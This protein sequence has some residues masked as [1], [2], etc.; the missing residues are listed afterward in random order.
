MNLINSSNP[1]EF[2]LKI[3]KISSIRFLRTSFHIDTCLTF[4]EQFSPGVG[5]RKSEQESVSHLNSHLHPP[6]TLS[7]LPP[8]IRYTSTH[9]L[10]IPLQ[11][12]T[13]ASNRTLVFS[14][15]SSFRP[16]PG[17]PLF[18]F[19][20]YFFFS[21]P[22]FILTLFPACTP[23]KSQQLMFLPPRYHSWGYKLRNYF[24]CY[25]SSFPKKKDHTHPFNTNI[26]HQPC[27]PKYLTYTITPLPTTII[28]PLPQ[29]QIHTLSCI[30][31]CVGS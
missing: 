8:M 26:F 3:L 20:F 25:S 28:L 11:V 2:L 4:S 6:T 7:I 31:H 22:P 13:L 15:Y 30:S 1:S 5:Y 16:V 21:L 9:F 10:N 23:M 14:S 18:Y 27:N 24:H 12:V 19:I 29:I 17:Y